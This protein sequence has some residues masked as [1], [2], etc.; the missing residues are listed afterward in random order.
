MSR[1]RCCSG[2]LVLTPSA[3]MI[4]PTINAARAVT[5]NIVSEYT[6]KSSCEHTAGGA[7]GVL[8]Q[9]RRCDN[10]MIAVI[11]WVMSSLWL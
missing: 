1:L 11:R 9:T 4:A 7:R 2:L 3:P 5:I 8:V 10:E 6:G